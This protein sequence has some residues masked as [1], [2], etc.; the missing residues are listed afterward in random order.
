MDN[1]KQLRNLLKP[2]RDIKASEEFRHKIET[3]IASKTGSRLRNGYVWA[4]ASLG[5]A[6]TILM[7]VIFPNKVSATDVLK[8]AIESFSNV[9]HIEMKA[10]IRTY[11]HEI[12]GH[13][14]PDAEFIPH[15]FIIQRK[16]SSTYWYINKGQRC[17]ENNSKGLYVWLDA[18]NIGW[19]YDEKVPDILGYLNI[20][21]NPEKIL[22]SEYKNL[23]I[24]AYSDCKITRKGEDIIFSIHS[25]PGGNYTNPYA[26]NTSIHES[27]NIRRYTL[28]AK[29]C[30][31]KYAS[32]SIIKDSQ[33]TEVLRVK[34]ISY[35]TNI[36]SLPSIPD[37][38]AFID[39]NKQMSGIPGL[40][41]IE[42]ASVFLNAFL[43]WNTDI[44][45][46]FIN[47][48]EAEEIYKSIYDK[49]KLLDIGYTFKSGSNSH[50]VFIPY[51]LRLKDGYIKKGNLAMANY[52]YG[53]W[54]FDGGL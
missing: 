26:L 34:D 32:V 44:L 13:I 33:E 39:E 2:R 31:L 52:Y 43:E 24:M 47:P 7:F 6:A 20:L 14:D 19:H 42:S 48:L 23:S 27:E 22:E 36:K 51:T 9:K 35:D 11:S 53:A 3:M 46:R 38:I 49:A 37:N 15:D 29:D 5:I 1:Y 45:Y 54:T 25:M 17:A 12:F 18:Y 40:N 8:N 41:A 30:R 50:I 16:D 21:I 4:A 10:E 28:D